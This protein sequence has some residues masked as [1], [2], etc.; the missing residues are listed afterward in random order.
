MIPLAWSLSLS[1]AL[2]CIGLFGILLQRS[3]L[4][5]LIAVELILN[6]ANINF[7]ASAHHHGNADGLV[8]TLII[9]ALAAA[10]AAVGL[11]ILIH[12]YRHVK[13]VD[14]DKASTL[15]W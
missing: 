14:T 11:A 7:V 8:F 10:E 5:L 9:I 3:A 4:R 12:L 2:F 13:T 1:A 15:R 6:A